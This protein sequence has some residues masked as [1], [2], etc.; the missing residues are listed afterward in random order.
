M[1]AYP[2][3]ILTDTNFPYGKELRGRRA[4]EPVRYQVRDFFQQQ[5]PT[6][7]LLLRQGNV[8]SSCPSIF[9]HWPISIKS[10]NETELVAS[11]SRKYCNQVP[12]E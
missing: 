10:I 6:L 2:L 8:V 3:T 5:Q 11:T 7:G 4:Y 12:T 9:N 1:I